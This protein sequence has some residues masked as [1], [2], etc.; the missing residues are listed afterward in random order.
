MSLPIFAQGASDS[1]TIALPFIVADPSNELLE[2]SAPV[3]NLETINYV[4]VE[5]W[6][7]LRIPQTKSKSVPQ[8]LS[9]LPSMQ[10]D[11]VLEVLGHLHPIM[12]L[13]VSRTNK[14][15]REL[16]RS[17]ITDLTW[18]NSF[19]V[20]AQLP[21]CP[22][23][24]SGRRWA[25][26]LFGPQICDECGQANTDADYIIWRRVCEICMDQNL[27]DEMPGYSASHELNSL[28]HRTH[29]GG[30][31]DETIDTELGRFWRSDGAILAS[32]YEAHNSEGGPEAVRRF[33]ESQAAVVS[34]NRERADR[35]ETWVLNSLRAALPNYSSML[36][37]VTDRAIKRL[38]SE[39]FHENDVNAVRYNIYQ[40]DALWR[41]P[42]LTSKVWH[43][44]RPDI[45]PA[46]LSAQTRRLELERE[47]RISHRKEAI[48]ATALMALRTPVPGSPRLYHPPPRAIESFAPIAQLISEESEKPLSRDDPQVAAA[49]VDAPAFVKTWCVETQTLLASLL[50]GADTEH[51]DL[52]L[53]DRATSVF[54]MQKPGNSTAPTAIGWE[55][56]R[57]HLYWCSGLPTVQLVEQELVQFG[58]RGAATAAAL[59]VLLGLNS[60]TATAAEMDAVDARLVCGTCPVAPRRR[61]LSWRE[62]VVHDVENTSSATAPHGEPSWLLLSPLATTDVR[63]REEP[64]DYSSLHIWSCMLCTEYAPGVATQIHVNNHIHSAHKIDHPVDGEHL[65]PFMGTER[66]RRRR[67]MLVASGEH[68]ARYRCN[69]CTQ[70]QPEIVK[71]FSER[72]ILPHLRDRHLVESPGADDWTET[73]LIME[74]DSGA[75]AT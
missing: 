45:L 32:L 12:L 21:E 19:L 33:L 4:T 74:A 22:C 48:L 39:G 26:L 15:F 13:Q 44:V 16:L 46:V 36:D 50:P 49:L 18:R 55:E 8:N 5:I 42:R 56:A 72:A 65:L 69:Y 47:L 6:K 70:A 61:A 43:R 3:R 17:P 66:P 59:A 31:R 27:L 9:M 64:D 63:R 40:C 52:R 38:I 41:V 14:S 53:L 10:L 71:L 73:N 11:I 34:E 68:P 54:R 51:P 58:R 25:K 7:S 62:C 1:E 75:A 35:C 2:P 60:D 37:K 29:R 67:V 28:V 57:V 24:I 30:F 23:Q 20:D